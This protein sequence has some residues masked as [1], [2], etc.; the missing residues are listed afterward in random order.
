MTFGFETSR[1]IL[2]NVSFEVT[3][4]TQ[5]A[6]VG[7]SGSGKSTILRLVSRNFDVEEGSIKVEGIDVKDLDLHSL[8]GA[9]GVVPQDC[10]LF[11]DTILENIRYSKP[12]A[13]KEEVEEAARLADL[14][15]VIMRMPQ[16]YETHV[17]ER[18]V[19]L[20]GGEKQRVAIA[21]VLLKVCSVIF[22]PVTL[23]TD[24]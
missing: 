9:I 5:V 6:V 2:K 15:R 22:R 20:S 11:N 24:L 17:G 16:Q 19:K 21:R 12:D 13:T 7:P 1:K 4:G 18:G 23:C 14:D 8:R 3:P 10:C